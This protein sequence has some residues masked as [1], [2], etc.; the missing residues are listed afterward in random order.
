MILDRHTTGSVNS[1]LPN[2]KSMKVNLIRDRG[3]NVY[4]F[5]EIA[6]TKVLLMISLI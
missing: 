1:A 5:R 2:N 6:A 4:P 3:Q